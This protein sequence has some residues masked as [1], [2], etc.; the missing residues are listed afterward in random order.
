METT[1]QSTLPFIQSHQALELEIKGPWLSIK[2][3]DKNPGLISKI[4]TA[5]Q[6]KIKVKEDPQDQGSKDITILFETYR[7][8]E[9]GVIQI[10]QGLATAVCNSINRPVPNRIQDGHLYKHGLHLME[11]V[12]KMETRQGDLIISP[13][14]TEI[15][16]E[17]AVWDSKGYGTNI[18]AAMGGG[19]TMVCAFLTLGAPELRPAVIAGRSD[20]DTR[21]LHAWMKRFLETNPEYDIPENQV[22][23]RVGGRTPNK[24]EQALLDQ[25]KG[26]VVITHRGCH[27]I[28]SDTKLLVID[29]CHNAATMNTMNHI[30]DNG[31]NLERV[32]TLSATT[33][34]RR[35]GGDRLP[36][37]ISNTTQILKTHTQF[38]KEGR[39]T[40]MRIHLHHFHP[41]GKYCHHE[42]I[43]G[44]IPSY[45][46][47]LI[48]RFVEKHRG[49]H[50]FVAD[51]VLD[52]P[53][54]EVKVIYTPKAEHALQIA[55]AIQKEIR[56]RI[57]MGTMDTI[58]AFTNQP[59]IMHAEG[60]GKKVRKISPE[61]TLGMTSMNGE[62]GLELKQEQE[63]LKKLRSTGKADLAD[64]KARLLAGNLKCV[65]VTDFMAVGLDTDSIDHVI[66]AS[67]QMAKAMSIQRS[68]RSVRPKEGKIA[69]YYIIVDNH[70]ETLF[71]PQRQK[72]KK[73]LEYYGLDGTSKPVQSLTGRGVT[74]TR[75]GIRNCWETIA[76]FHACPDPEEHGGFSVDQVFKSK[77]A[78]ELTDLIRRNLGTQ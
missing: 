70:H 55:S 6:V 20:T 74:T 41:D 2:G 18:N 4:A 48:N 34:M 11:A 59:V 66:D 35:D 78:N 51:V 27:N 56:N 73:V 77:S 22:I 61:K 8:R 23:L 19:K 45:G 12:Q 63:M 9:N 25:G 39:V 14:Q 43:P 13:T 50:K 57:L 24:K 7:I 38:E 29:E 16:C 17:A 52:I 26:I 10:P 37:I 69:N 1:E 76:L 62:E 71:Y 36:A 75:R 46:Y 31:E 28:P 64:M 49:R 15:L 3:A 40:P 68:G 47:N 65:V 32:H 53:G 30:F 54:D 33:N 60:T 42:G 44:S 21:Q 58:S 72:V 5:S 67:G